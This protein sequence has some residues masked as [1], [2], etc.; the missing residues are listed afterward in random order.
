MP[1]LNVHFVYVLQD[2]TIKI[3]DQPFDFNGLVSVVFV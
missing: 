3:E 2:S 1:S